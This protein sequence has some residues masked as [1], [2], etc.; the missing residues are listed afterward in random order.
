[1][2]ESIAS[3]DWYSAHQLLISLAQRHQRARR[4]AEALR[5]LSSGLGDMCK[6]G[7]GDSWPPLPTILDIA[8]KFLEIGG[9]QQDEGL[10]L[11]ECMIVAG[12]TLDACVI[13][14]GGK[15]EKHA[16]DWSPLVGQLV[17]ICPDLSEP[18]WKHL[19][20]SASV[21]ADWKTSWAVEHLSQR[22][23]IWPDLGA[24]L[25]DQ[26]DLAAITTLQ[27]LTF[28]CFGSASGLLKGFLQKLKQASPSLPLTAIDDANGSLPS[29]FTLVGSE[30][31]NNFNAAQMIFIVC[32]R[33]NPSKALFA[34]LAQHFKL[35]GDG[36]MGGLVELLARIYS[37]QPKRPTGAADPMAMNPLAS[38]FQNMFMGG[39]GAGMQMPSMQQPARK[40]S[41]P[42]SGRKQLDL[43]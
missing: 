18:F 42:T 30:A 36:E 13:A 24:G 38:M 8:G 10:V 5:M 7:Q 21:Q 6:E 11:D 43:D 31:Y 14:L 19:S 16:G 2:S 20:A 32:Q 41:S 39:G 4:H 27:L 9:Q 35:D 34:Q 15:D 29:F 25:R 1:M 37:P 22:K 23:E 12:R 26:P 40:P 33:R 28:K 3:Q 17:A